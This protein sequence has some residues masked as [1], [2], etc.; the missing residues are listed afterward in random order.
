MHNNVGQ[1]YVIVVASYLREVTP[2]KEEPMNTQTKVMNRRETGKLADYSEILST[3][4]DIKSALRVFAVKDDTFMTNI[5]LVC[6]LESGEK[7]YQA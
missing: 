4:S 3:R 6:I 2:G 1:C 5:A 7:T